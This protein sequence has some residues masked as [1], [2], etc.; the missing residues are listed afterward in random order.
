MRIERSSG[1]KRQVRQLVR[2]YPKAIDDIEE[3]VKTLERGETPGNR[4][5]GLGGRPVYWARIRNSSTGR[6]QSGGFRIVYFC[7]QVVVLLI[8][9]GI[10]AEF[11]TIATSHV[12]QILR[13]N[14][15]G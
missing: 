12:E 5:T 10:R 4:M 1:F 9:I 13:N 8:M 7:D 6:G 15:F 11:G 2:K 3:F 14:G